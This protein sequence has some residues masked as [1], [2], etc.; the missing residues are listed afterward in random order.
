MGVLL[1]KRLLP[2]DIKPSGLATAAFYTGLLA[3]TLI[4]APLALILGLLAVKDIR[5]NPG[6]EG[7][8]G[9]YFGLIAGAIGTTGF[10]KR[11][12]QH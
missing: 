11:V 8:V 10:V 4:F 9:A 5:L 12:I 7:I 2:D 6:K 3:I 1:K